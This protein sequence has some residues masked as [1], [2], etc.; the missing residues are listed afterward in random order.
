MKGI[1]LQIAQVG[2]HHR[3]AADVIQLVENSPAQRGPFGGIGAR[4]QLIEQD[5]ALGIR[6]L[7]DAGDARDVRTEGAE[8][9][10]QA[11]LV[12]NVREDIVEDRHA[13]AVPGRHVHAAL[14]H[15]AQQAG[16]LERHRFAAGVGPGD[17]EDVEAVA[18]ADVDGH[19]FERW[20]MKRGLAPFLTE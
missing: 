10:L 17:D 1:R 8:R 20:M 14:G 9:L 19:D 11:L 13:A 5:Q 7:Q 2:R 6:G 12:A 3:P 4:S 15:Q 16:R 18:Q